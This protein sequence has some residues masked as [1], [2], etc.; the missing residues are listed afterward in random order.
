M[1]DF[2]NHLT[3]FLGLGKIEVALAEAVLA[4]YPQM[5]ALGT[6][7]GGNLP[8]GQSSAHRRWI[9]DLKKLQQG[10]VDME[11]RATKM[12][13]EL[14]Q[15]L[16]ELS[17]AKTI[18]DWENPLVRKAIKKEVSRFHNSSGGI[19][20]RESHKRRL[21]KLTDEVFH[22]ILVFHKGVIHELN[23]K[24]FSCSEAKSHVMTKLHSLNKDEFEEENKNLT[25]Y[26]RL[27]IDMYVIPKHLDGKKKYASV[28]HLNTKFRLDNLNTQ[29]IW[30]KTH[31]GWR[32]DSRTK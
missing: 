12:K 14:S 1:K 6:F 3:Q 11:I 27:Y 25:F 5:N 30:I 15:Y 19:G 9:E 28:R 26:N 8:H 22:N 10:F 13:V 7:S 17:E 21:P 16:H 20:V 24:R 29:E 32:F 23:V 2:H 18:P 4:R 31:S